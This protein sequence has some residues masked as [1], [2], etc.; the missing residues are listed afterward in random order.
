MTTPLPEA[1]AQFHNFII[2]DGPAP[3]AITRSTKRATA[4][5]L[6]SIYYNGYRLSMLE[7]IKNDFPALKFL[8]GDDGFGAL[9]QDYI[10]Q[11]KSRHYSIR[12]YGQELSAFIA[13]NPK[14][15]DRAELAELA[16]WKWSLGSATDAADADAIDASAFAA[17]EPEDWAGLKFLFH[18]SLS[19]QSLSWSVPAFRQA[20]DD[21]ETD[22]AQPQLLDTP[23]D[24][25]IWRDGTLIL[26]RSL[27]EDESGALKA[28]RSGA[29]FGALCEA[30]TETQG[31]KAAEAGGGYL[32]A[33]VEQGWITGIVS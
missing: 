29:S 25:A 1:Q 13:K 9:G 33:W 14:W 18:P 12:W 11:V 10:T 32:R 31:D 21:G 8:L 24:W 27:D 15:Q 3:V 26:Y 23:V 6:L 16:A 19:Q 20:F 17:I 2:N 28:A 7:A 5:Q 30:L 4:E 22:P